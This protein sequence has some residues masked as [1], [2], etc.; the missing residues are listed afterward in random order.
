MRSEAK[1]AAPGSFK[2]AREPRRGDRRA[3]PFL[4]ALQA[5]P[6]LF[7]FQ[8]LRASRLPLATFWPRLRRYRSG[9]RERRYLLAARVALPSGRAS[10]AT[11]ARV[12]LPSGCASGATVLAD[13]SGATVLAV[14]AALPSG[15]ACGATVIRVLLPKRV[16][17]TARAD[18]NAAVRNRGGGVTLVVQLVDRQHF[19]FAR[20]LQH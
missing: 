20:G 12:A 7:A 16:Q 2:K 9:W 18:V 3:P 11:A 8:G 4:S 14:R 13:A 15:R 19:P 6:L 5:C 10:G 17:R 1:H